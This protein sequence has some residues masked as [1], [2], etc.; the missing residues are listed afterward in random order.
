MSCLNMQSI[1]QDF[2]ERNKN[3]KKWKRKLTEKG[4]GKEGGGVKRSVDGFY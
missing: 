1:S 2:V 4:Q 3:R